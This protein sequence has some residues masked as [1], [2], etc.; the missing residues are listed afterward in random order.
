[1]LLPGLLRVLQMLLWCW[2][3]P[4]MRNTGA[5]MHT[6]CRSQ[7]VRR[8]HKLRHKPATVADW[9]AQEDSALVHHTTAATCT[10]HPGPL[11]SVA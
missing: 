9:A 3:M 2:R 8:G 4:L 1:M 7:Q 10:C 11:G 6:Y 5:A